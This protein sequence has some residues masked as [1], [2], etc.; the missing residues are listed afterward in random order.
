MQRNAENVD[1]NWTWQRLF[2]YQFIFL[3]YTSSDPKKVALLFEKFIT[4]QLDNLDKLLLL[5]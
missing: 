5:N 2:R 1:V 4:S 3:I